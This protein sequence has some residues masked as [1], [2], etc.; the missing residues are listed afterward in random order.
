MKITRD[1]RM[2][3][4]G[5]TDVPLSFADAVFQFSFIDC[6]CEIEYSPELFKSFPKAK[7][8]HEGVLVDGYTIPHRLLKQTAYRPF[9]MQW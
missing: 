9:K 8:M 5:A 2:R 4:C 1:L 7:L 3:Q 6:D